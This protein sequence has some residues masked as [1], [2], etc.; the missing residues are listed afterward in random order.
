ME[1]IYG[2]IILIAIIFVLIATLQVNLCKRE[3]RKAGLILPALSVIASVLA[4]VGIIFYA[5]PPNLISILFTALQVFM[6]M[7]IPTV[8]LMGIYMSYH[9]KRMKAA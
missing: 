9:G 7:N 5:M 1:P 3:S 4:V 6:M 2:I 8:I